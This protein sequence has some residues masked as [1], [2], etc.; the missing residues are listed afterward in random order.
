M[1]AICP[2][3]FTSPAL[4]QEEGIVQEVGVLGAETKNLVALDNLPKAKEG[5]SLD[6]VLGLS[7]LELMRSALSAL[8]HFTPPSNP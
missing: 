2:V 6:S 5:E 3:A 1:G 7:Y 8:P 4:T